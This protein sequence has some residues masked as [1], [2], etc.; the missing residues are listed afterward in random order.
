M[1]HKYK[2]KK[3]EEQGIVTDNIDPQLHS[4]RKLLQTIGWGMVSVPYLMIAHGI[5][6]TTYNFSVT[7]TEIPLN[8]LPYSLNGLRIVQI[9]DIH[10][11][12]FNDPASLKEVI[13]IINNLTPDILVIS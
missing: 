10:A 11:G 1:I 9:S 3:V 4:R 5:A 6:N 8:K 2:K 12:S 13:Y 7:Y